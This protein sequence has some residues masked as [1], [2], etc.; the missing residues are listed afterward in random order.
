M[1]AHRSCG[2]WPVEQRDWEYATLYRNIPVSIP[3]CFPVDGTRQP[4][5]P[6]P[7]CVSCLLKEGAPENSGCDDAQV[8]TAQAPMLC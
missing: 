2:H 7:S 4:P 8:H 5:G 6:D 3:V 1:H